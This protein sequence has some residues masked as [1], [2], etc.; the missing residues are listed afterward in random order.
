[1]QLYHVYV[2][3]DDVKE[4]GLGGNKSN[5]QSSD[6]RLKKKIAIPL[7]NTLILGVSLGI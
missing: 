1:M 4:V 6:V 5:T 7:V 3:T 2:L